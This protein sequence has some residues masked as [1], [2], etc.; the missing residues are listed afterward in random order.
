MSGDLGVNGQHV[1]QDVGK[2]GKEIARETDK[3]ETKQGFLKILLVKDSRKKLL[4][5]MEHYNFGN[6]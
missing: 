3:E 2:V 4:I 1:Q 5:A 6:I